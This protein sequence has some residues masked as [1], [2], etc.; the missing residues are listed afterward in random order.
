[1]RVA[2]QPVEI[3]AGRTAEGVVK[4][5]IQGGYHTN[6]NPASYPYLIATELDLPDAGDITV[7]YI[8]YP[9]PLIKKF[10]FAEKPLRVYEGETPLT[11]NLQ[12]AQT[13]AKGKRT[14]PA[15]LHIQACDDQVCYAPGT[16][17]VAIPV[18][19]K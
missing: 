13:A 1:M 12:A 19:I 18:T 7:D 11:I 17:E 4:L 16:I 2:P 10:P 3:T 8:Y 5:T 14:L 6:A 15:K 9:N